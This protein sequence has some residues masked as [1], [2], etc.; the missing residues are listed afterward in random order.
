MWTQKGLKS[1]VLLNGNSSIRNKRMLVKNKSSEGSK[2]TSNSKYT[3]KTDHYNTVIVVCKLLI[4]WVER[5]TYWGMKLKCE[6]NILLAF[7]LL[8]C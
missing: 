1:K 6:F 4:S 3:N 7:S 8:V 2:L 5:W